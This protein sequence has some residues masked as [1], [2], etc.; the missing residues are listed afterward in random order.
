MLDVH[1]S[2]S[3]DERSDEEHVGAFRAGLSGL[4]LKELRARAKQA[5]VDEE[6]LENATDCDDPK[7]AVTE[8][9]VRAFQRGH[10]DIELGAAD[11]T[12]TRNPV[13]AND[14]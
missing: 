8:L 4:R 12:E 10:S 1:I 13:S 9:L 7:A 6:A 3:N 2:V 11:A 14:V 5:G